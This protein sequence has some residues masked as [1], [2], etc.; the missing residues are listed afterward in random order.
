M[1]IAP[2]A[3]SRFL[4]FQVRVESRALLKTLSGGRDEL[5][6]I[7]RRICGSIC[8]SKVRKGPATGLPAAFP[9]SSSLLSRGLVFSP[10][11]LGE[12]SSISFVGHPFQGETFLA[13]GGVLLAHRPTPRGTEPNELLRWG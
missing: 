9:R 1:C 8:S 12:G 10:D 13:S 7:E 4:P 11:K 5:F 2:H 6:L 3:Y